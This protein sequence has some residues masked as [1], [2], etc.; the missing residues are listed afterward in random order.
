MS[1]S[2]PGRSTYAG[3]FGAQVLL[4]VS[5]GSL[6]KSLPVMAMAYYA[7]LRSWSRSVHTLSTLHVCAFTTHSTDSDTDDDEGD[8]LEQAAVLP[9]G[10]ISPITPLTAL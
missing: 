5:S 7:I 6:V 3:W 8:A 9:V 10:E 4:V 1:T 2:V